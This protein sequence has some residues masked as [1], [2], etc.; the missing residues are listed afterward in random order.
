MFCI[1]VQETPVT[2]I[3]ECAKPGTNGRGPC[4]H[5]CQNTIGS[6]KCYCPAGSILAPDGVSCLMITCPKCMHGGYCNTGT[7][8]CVCPAGFTGDICQTGLYYTVLPVLV[9]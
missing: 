1:T 9:F 4:T 6:Y 5:Q 2:D 8:E 7:N 3:D